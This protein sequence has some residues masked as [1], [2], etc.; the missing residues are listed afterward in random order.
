[1]TTPAQHP[2][3]WPLF[4]VT[5]GGYRPFI[6]AAYSRSA[7]RYASFLDWTDGKFGDFLRRVSIRKVPATAIVIDPYDYVRRN[8]RRDIRHGT[9]VKITGEGAGLE[10]AKGTVIHPGRESTAYAHVVLDGSKHAMTVHP[11]SIIVEA[12]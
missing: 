5:V 7:A 9:R 3:P 6:V 10:G 11:L 1:M 8:Y 2:A 4:E 12:A